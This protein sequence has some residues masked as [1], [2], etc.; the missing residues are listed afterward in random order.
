MTRVSNTMIGLL[1]LLTLLI[2]IPIIG[3]GLW[4]A[5]STATCESFL[6][7]PLMV[8]GF[9]ILL[10]SLAGFIGACFH[11]V[12]ALWLYLAVMLFLI[13]ALLAVTVFGF[14]V[15]GPGGGIV[16]P[17]RA[18]KEYH[19]Q[20]Y[21]PWLRKRIEK[22]SYWMTVRSCILGSKTCSNIV[23]WTPMDYMTRNLSPIQSG[24][25]KPPTSCDYQAPMMTQD[26]DCYK[27][28]ND[29]NLLCYECDSCKAG[30]LEDVRRDW[31][32]LSI[33]NIIMVMLLIVIYFVGCCAFQNAK[34][35]DDY[36]SYPESRMYKARPKWNFY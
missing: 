20:S 31:H 11:V 29:P 19:L 25:C 18:Y 9:V 16:V 32:R 21:S 30:V 12:W 17:G 10:V 2:S 13:A 8:V 35:A 36:Y 6:Q 4:M 33:L 34:R 14:V 3:G 28:N 26:P 22:P 27:W 23:T 7:R 15:V 5:K 24:C 1:N